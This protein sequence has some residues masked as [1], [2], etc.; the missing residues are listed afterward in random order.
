MQ[1]FPT[2]SA[3]DVL[4][5][6]ESAQ[7]SEVAHRRSLFNKRR[8]LDEDSQQIFLKPYGYSIK[9]DV[10][11]PVPSALTGKRAN[12]IPKPKT[13]SL[14]ESTANLSK[15]LSKSTATPFELE[16][17]EDILGGEQFSHLLQDDSKPAEK[18]TALKKPVAKVPGK[19]A[20]KAKAPASRIAIQNKRRPDQATLSKRLAEV[21]AK[22]QARRR[23]QAAKAP[24]PAVLK[25]APASKQV[26]RLAAPQKAP[27]ANAVT[28]STL[29]VS[30]PTVA[31][32][33][34]GLRPMWP[35]IGF[36]GAAFIGGGIALAVMKSKS[37]KNET[38]K[39]EATGNMS[40]GYGYP[41]MQYRM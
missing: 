19:P 35:A 41:M 40:G 12:T 4:G 14:K 29:G 36:A 34:K 5:D 27:K 11:A 6:T 18:K 21:Q 30:A 32:Y 9:E 13:R 23:E 10:I 38:S 26:S 28:S 25:Q 20:P 2:G 37:G 24:T 15:R 17:A 22:L 8:N 1:R 7:A 3:I 33:K 39:S 16:L 31:H